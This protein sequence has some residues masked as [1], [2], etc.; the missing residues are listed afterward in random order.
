V[1][2]PPPSKTKQTKQTSRLDSS[3]QD[4]IKKTL[5]EMGFIEA[6]ERLANG[7]RPGAISHYRDALNYA[8]DNESYYLRLAE[9]LAED[10]N[11]VA[12]AE[13]LLTKAVELAPNNMELRSKLAEIREE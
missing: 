9:V 1:P 10:L 2:P 6:N 13:Q 11:T 12:E 5:A 3:D 7:D 8:P 4:N